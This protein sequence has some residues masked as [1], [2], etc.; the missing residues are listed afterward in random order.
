MTR[1]TTSASRSFTGAAVPGILGAAASIYFVLVCWHT[2]NPVWAGLDPFARLVTAAAA[3]LVAMIAESIV[4]WQLRLVSRGVVAEAIVDEVHVP[5]LRPR[6]HTNATVFYHFV[7]E[8]HHTINA[9]LSVPRSEAQ[10]WHRLHFNVIYDASK[11]RRHAHDERLWA[12]EW[13]ITEPEKPRS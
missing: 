9:R 3:I 1:T 10:M 2:Q 6:G 11:P 8:E 13:E 12:V 5:I 7:T 4:R